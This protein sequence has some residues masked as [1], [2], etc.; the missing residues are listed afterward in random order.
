MP[1]GLKQNFV[2]QFRQP[3]QMP[4]GQTRFGDPRNPPPMWAI[5]TDIQLIWP[6]LRV[7]NPVKT[8]EYSKLHEVDRFIRL[9]PQTRETPV[10]NRPKKHVVPP[11]FRCAVKSPPLRS[12]GVPAHLVALGVLRLL[13]IQILFGHLS[14][15]AVE[16]TPPWD[17]WRFSDMIDFEDWWAAHC[18]PQGKDVRLSNLG[19]TRSGHILFGSSYC[20]NFSKFPI[21]SDKFLMQFKS[22]Q[23]S[24]CR[25]KCST[26]PPQKKNVLPPGSRHAAAWALLGARL[27]HPLFKESICLA[28]SE[29]W[30]IPTFH[31]EIMG[32]SLE[33]Y[34]MILG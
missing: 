26:P 22:H 6:W 16:V 21:L 29:V 7:K 12:L 27:L 11:S 5:P 32:I 10:S 14:S 23:S 1:G 20:L 33:R 2:P 30:K 18:V 13:S 28:P 3:E 34:W 31:G 4:T 9:S 15:E 8:P 17:R 25:S 24:I 19:Y